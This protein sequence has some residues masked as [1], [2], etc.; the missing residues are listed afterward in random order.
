MIFAFIFQ[1]LISFNQV[2]QEILC[3]C[4]FKFQFLISLIGDVHSYTSS[5]FTM[6]K[7][8]LVQ[9]DAK[10]CRPSDQS[11]KYGLFNYGQSH[12][13][14]LPASLPIYYN[15]WVTRSAWFYA[16]FALFFFALLMNYAIFPLL[17]IY[18]FNQFYGVLSRVIIVLLRTAFVSDYFPFNSLLVKSCINMP[19][20]REFHLHPPEIKILC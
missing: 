9:G 16:I 6:V 2:K 7:F 12:S 15:H 5:L 10:L 4:F 18:K 19:S 20:C 14:A 11:W 3:I 8:G 17:P 13:F 1:N